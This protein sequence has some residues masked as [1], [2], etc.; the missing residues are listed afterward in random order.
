MQFLEVLF[1]SVAIMNIILAI[2][3]IF[4]WGGNYRANHTRYR[5]LY[6]IWILISILFGGLYIY[7]AIDFTPGSYLANATI[8]SIIIRPTISLVLGASTITAETVRHLRLMERLLH[9]N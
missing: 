1:Y 6:A 7:I 9:D 8:S 4:E 5:W 2:V 3:S